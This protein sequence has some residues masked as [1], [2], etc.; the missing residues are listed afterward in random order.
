M[1]RSF[2]LQRLCPL[3]KQMR[4]WFEVQTVPAKSIKVIKEKSELSLTWLYV[5]IMSRT[6]FRV[7]PQSIIWL[8]V[9]ELLARSRC[10]IWSL[11]K[12]NLILTHN[13]L[14]RKGILNHLVKLTKWLSCVLSTYVLV[15]FGSIL[16]C[17]RVWIHS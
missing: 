7:N 5:I 1:L 6:S 4:S 15:V 13:Y 10:H 17:Y 8:N 16:L 9:K 11:S 12:S 3:L 14:A 2:I